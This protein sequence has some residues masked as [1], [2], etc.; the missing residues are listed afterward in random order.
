MPWAKL[1]A[2]CCWLG[3]FPIAFL[4][5]EM[6]AEMVDVNVHPT[7][8]E[9]RFQDGGR[10]Y[11]QLLGTLR[12][13][14]SGD[15]PDGPP[16]SSLSRHAPASVIR[17]RPTIPPPAHEPESRGP[18]AANRTRRL[19]QRATPGKPSKRSAGIFGAGSFR[20]GGQASAGT[21]LLSLPHE[22]PR[23]P[24]RPLDECRLSTAARFAGIF[25]AVFAEPGRFPRLRGPPSRRQ[26]R[27]VRCQNSHVL[28]PAL[29][30][31][32]KFTIAI[33]CRER[34]KGWW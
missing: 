13:Q 30:R 3:R 24:H 16:G 6:P 28:P 10:L 29:R 11:S 5:I 33:L 8:L 34:T 21:A 15:R 31:R 12:T 26:T 9:V 32:C 2:G 19:G 27:S 14:V 20:T 25:A 18:Q 22:F 1:T 7:K 23:L 4:R 17:L